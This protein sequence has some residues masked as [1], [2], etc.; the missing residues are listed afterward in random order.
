MADAPPAV[1]WVECRVVGVDDAPAVLVPGNE[2]PVERELP[3]DEGEGE[4]FEGEGVFAGTAG[5]GLSGRSVAAAA[6]PPESTRQA[7]AA[8][9]AIRYR[10]TRS[11]RSVMS[12]TGTER[13][14]DCPVAAAS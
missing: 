8:S 11:P 4:G 12:E 13:V 1:P 9:A 3:V 10:R 14:R 2:W 7:P 5:R 6:A